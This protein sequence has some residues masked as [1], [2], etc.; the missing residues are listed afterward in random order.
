MNIREH[1]LAWRWTDEK[2]A[3]LPDNI[4]REMFPV[5]ETEAAG[6]F[7]RSLT[8]IRDT[9]LSPDIFTIT[10][11]SANPFSAEAGCRWLRERQP[12]LSVPVVLSWDESTA[13][14][15]IWEVFTN[16]W[17]DF[18]YPSS[19]D[20]LVWPESESW[21]LLYHHA[22]EFRF[23]KRRAATRTRTR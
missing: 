6:L 20:V 23:G 19:D 16:Y 7:T 15:T 21:V 13:I 17:D 2:Y 14:R 22:H 9:D 8:F 11:I 1:P 3:L 12:D 5:E 10:A 18:C 4:L